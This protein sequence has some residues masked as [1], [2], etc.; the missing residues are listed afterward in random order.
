MSR[1]RVHGLSVSAPWLRMLGQ[2]V[3]LSVSA[4]H[5]CECLDKELRRS[6]IN[7]SSLFI[8]AARSCLLLG[9]GRK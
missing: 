8:S 6:A 9:A 1:R 3:C 4:P 2:G 7:T 5:G